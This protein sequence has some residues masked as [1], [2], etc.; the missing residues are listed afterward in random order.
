[1]DAPEMKEKQRRAGWTKLHVVAFVIYRWVVLGQFGGF[2][3]SIKANISKG[4]WET[5]WHSL[6]DVLLA[7]AGVSAITTKWIPKPLGS[8]FLRV[9]SL[10]CWCFL[11]AS[12]LVCW[13]PKRTSTQIQLVRL[14]GCLHVYTGLFAP[15]RVHGKPCMMTWAAYTKIGSPR[16]YLENDKISLRRRPRKKEKTKLSVPYLLQK[17]AKN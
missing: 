1:M 12:L 9:Q 16:N 13:E 11:L 8:R 4:F 5:H 3:G 17:S 15:A 14:W 10:N 6:F 2:S 7:D